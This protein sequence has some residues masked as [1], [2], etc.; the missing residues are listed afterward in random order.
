M[1]GQILA[2]MLIHAVG[3]ILLS[4]FGG[5]G[6]IQSPQNSAEHR[7]GKRRDHELRQTL[8]EFAEAQGGEARKNN[9]SVTLQRHDAKM[10]VIGDRQG[11]IHFKIRWKKSGA[12][13]RLKVYSQILLYLSEQTL[14]ERETQ[15]GDPDFDKEYV[16]VGEN[17]DDARKVLNAETRTLIRATRD[18]ADDVRLVFRDGD[19]ELT[20]PGEKMN[21]ESLGQLADVVFQLHDSFRSAVDPEVLFIADPHINISKPTTPGNQPTCQICGEEIHE[22]KVD[23]LACDSPHHRECWD[24]AGACSIYGCGERHCVASPG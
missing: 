17:A 23:C 2:E 8:R 9:R 19:L 4:P 18:L 21:C 1:V 13:V 15:I 6:S 7:E 16:V 22:E 20:T 11:K 14:E 5:N 3:W 12:N 24:Y 10:I